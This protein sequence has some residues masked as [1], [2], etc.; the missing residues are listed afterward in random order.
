MKH[1][2]NENGS[3]FGACLQRYVFMCVRVCVFLCV[4]VL[5]EGL[6]EVGSGDWE[7]LGLAQRKS[8][9]HIS[10]CIDAKAK[11]SQINKTTEDMDVE[12]CI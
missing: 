12:Y 10:F 1:I 8:L 2:Q 5:G 4:F 6:W 7:V 11:V 3:G 9:A